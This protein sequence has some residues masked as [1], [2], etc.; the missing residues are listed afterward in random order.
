MPYGD[1]GNFELAFHNCRNWEK[2]EDLVQA[3]GAMLDRFN[4]QVLSIPA[5]SPLS[6]NSFGKSFSDYCHLN[7]EKCER[8]WDENYYPPHADG[9][10]TLRF[11]IPFIQISSPP[12]W[13]YIL[14]TSSIFGKEY[15]QVRFNIYRT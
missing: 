12:I 10:L 2:T 13:D 15:N 14:M 1:G 9:G 11:T 6:F 8:N 4:F 5:F 3:L 7:Y